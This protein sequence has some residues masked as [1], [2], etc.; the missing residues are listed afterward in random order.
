MKS[1]ED[2]AGGSARRRFVFL[3]GLI[4]VNTVLMFFNLF[5]ARRPSYATFNFLCCSVAW[6]GVLLVEKLEEARK[7]SDE[8][9][10][11]SNPS[12]NGEDEDD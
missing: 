8:N 11:I 4:V 3:Y 9:G 5:V 6:I 2:P 1:T 12:D 7:Q 10:S